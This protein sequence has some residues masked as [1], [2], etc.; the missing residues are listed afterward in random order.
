MTTGREPVDA[1]SFK[2]VSSDDF[3]DLGR[4]KIKEID[5]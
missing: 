4:C 1:V 2:P 3:R 5:M